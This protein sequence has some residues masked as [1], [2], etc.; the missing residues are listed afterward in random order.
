MPDATSLIEKSGFIY[1]ENH[2]HKTITG[3]CGTLIPAGMIQGLAKEKLSVPKP[4][5]RL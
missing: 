5:I 4:C 1:R 2:P 3:V